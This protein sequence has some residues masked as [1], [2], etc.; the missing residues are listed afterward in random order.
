MPWFIPVEQ[1]LSCQKVSG[2]LFK[3]LC[4]YGLHCA[5]EKHILSEGS[6]SSQV[7]L[8]VVHSR[9]ALHGSYTMALSVTGRASIKQ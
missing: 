1:F 7:S 6:N 5:M 4:S 8:L 2:L 3:D 9:A